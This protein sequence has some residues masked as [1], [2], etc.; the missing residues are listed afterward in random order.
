M[1]FTKN[2][3]FTSSFP[4]QI[5]FISLSSLIAEASSSKT[6]L[7][8]SSKSGH[9]CFIPD[10]RRNAFS[11]SLEYV[12]CGFVICVLCCAHLLKSFLIK[13][14]VEFYQKLFLHRKFLSRLSGY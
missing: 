5:P 8:K 2:D 6:M 12:S 14:D 4:I 1:S 9:P 3:Y 11:M 10:L 13:M 7:N